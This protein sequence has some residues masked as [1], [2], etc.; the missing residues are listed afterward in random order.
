[1]AFTSGIPHA[2]DNAN[3][4]SIGARKLSRS[5]SQARMGS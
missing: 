2:L 5:Y 3:I 4:V 1:M